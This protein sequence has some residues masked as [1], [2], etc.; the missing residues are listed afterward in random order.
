MDKDITR[1]LNMMATMPSTYMPQ[2]N[3]VNNNE[4]ENYIKSIQSITNTLSSSP[5][6]KSFVPTESLKNTTTE[7]Y[8]FTP[9]SPVS[10]SESAFGS[11][12]NESP[13]M[14]NSPPATPPMDDLT[15]MNK[16]VNNLLGYPFIFGNNYM[17]VME[18]QNDAKRAIPTNNR[19]T[20]RPQSQQP[21]QS[22]AKRVKLENG[23]VAKDA[24]A[25]ETAP[26]TEKKKKEGGR[27]II[28]YNCHTDTTPLWRRTPDRLHSLCNACGLYYKQ[29]KTHRPLNLQHK[30]SKSGKKN[31]TNGNTNSSSSS[32]TNSSST[33]SPAKVTI[34][35]M[36]KSE[37]PL[38][39]SDVKLS[40]SPSNIFLNNNTVNYT[41]SMDLLNH[42]A[43]SNNF[44][45]TSSPLTSNVANDSLLASVAAT[46]PQI[47]NT[48]NS[49]TDIMNSSLLLNNTNILS[50]VTFLNN[51]KT[52]LKG[53]SEDDF[54][55]MNDKSMMNGNVSSLMND[56][57][58][59]LITKTTE[60]M[61]N[62]MMNTQQEEEK[63][64][65]NEVE[66]MKRED[67]QR[68]LTNYEKRCEFL[69]GY[70]MATRS[71]N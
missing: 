60:E 26:K 1:F 55:Y 44:L 37:S 51:Q 11:E 42:V 5:S 14:V 53:K 65:R 70:L 15:A 56:T 54:L 64:F 36:V 3:N 8:T 58:S 19:K 4:L 38:L 17:P 50:S 52:S 59:Y 48:L 45:A 31:S 41:S 16:N 35:P 25:T 7:N 13:K 68:L 32:T 43:T 2:E 62:G 12:A 67:V 20:P 30:T 10:D 46:N 71:R 9:L 47:L 61:Q 6:E 23:M 34:Q 69:R 28:C 29:Y 39:S 21:Q 22:A 33:T 40:T 27:K 63:K 24:N 57:S 49:N 66:C 18:P